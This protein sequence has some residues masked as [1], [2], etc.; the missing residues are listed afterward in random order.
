M[1]RG[2]ITPG[3]VT[4]SARTRAFAARPAGACLCILAAGVSLW[5]GPATAVEVVPKPALIREVNPLSIR[6][7]NYYPSLTPWDACWT[8]TPD[9]VFAA[10]LALAAALNLNSVRIFLPWNEKTEAAGLIAADGVVSAVYLARFDAF[11]ALA[12]QHG[13]RVLPCFAL[14]YHLRRP[15]VP[16]AWKTAMRG[17]VEPHRD[18]GRILM[19]DLMNEPERTEWDEESMGYLREA[20]VYLKTVDPHHLSTVGIGW[21]MDR[22]AP[23][24]VPDV[25]QY[26]NYAPKEEMFAQGVKRVG[27]TVEMLQRYGGARPVLIGEFGL[28][29]ARDPQFGAGPAWQD[30]LG[31]AP[32]S[33]AEQALLYGIILNAAEVYRL[34]GT[35]SWCLVSFPAREEGFLTPRESMFGMTRLDGTLKPAAI[36]LRETY[37]KWKTWEAE[38]R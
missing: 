25:L 28:S 35:M 2:E 7:T 32:G 13:I 19:W 1:A 15:R 10:D 4:R 21:Q 3:R 37:G 22:L 6:G 27:G 33:E 14:E 17:F 36:L 26:H 24:G 16:T 8:E 11:L 30:R 12:W 34:A 31:P 38:G 29:T 23:A 18:D 9:A 20:Q 5:S